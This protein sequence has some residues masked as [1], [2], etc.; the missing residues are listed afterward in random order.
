VESIIRVHGF[1]VD[2][3]PTAVPD[4]PAIA[5]YAQGDEW[6]HF[7]RF[8]DGV[9]SSKL[10]DGNDIAGVTLEDLEGKLYGKVVKVLSRPIDTCQAPAN[11]T[12]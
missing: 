1:T 8:E 5:I 7:A 12:E 4:A 2:I 3:E 11:G 9:W 10:G 6:T